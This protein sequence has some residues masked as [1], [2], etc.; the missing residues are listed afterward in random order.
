MV[1]YITFRPHPLPTDGTSLYAFVY[2]CIHC[3]HPPSEDKIKI[4]NTSITLSDK[5]ENLCADLGLP[6][7]CGIF[8]RLKTVDLQ[9]NRQ[10]VSTSANG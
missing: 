2:K 5:I 8:Q 3:Y 6:E 1:S 4:C 10:L 9:H 7:H